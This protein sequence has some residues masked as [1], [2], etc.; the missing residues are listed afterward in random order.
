[1]IDMSQQFI[2]QATE[3]SD[4]ALEHGMEAASADERTAPTEL[5]AQLDQLRTSYWRK[6]IK[7]QGRIRQLETIVAEQEKVL[8]AVYGSRSWRI[9]SPLRETLFWLSV[10]KTRAR[11]LIRALGPNGSVERA[12]IRRRLQRGAR[13]P[14]WAEPRGDSYRQWFDQ[15]QALSDEDVSLIRAHLARGKFPHV[16]V[17]WQLDAASVDEVAD[18]VRTLQQQ[19]HPGWTANLFVPEEVTRSDAISRL[20]KTE[21]RIRC[22]ASGTNPDC[23]EQGPL[24]LIDR[25]G[26]LAPHA[27][28]LLLERMQRE[29]DIAVVLCDEDEVSSDGEHRNPRFVGKYSAELPT[30]GSVALLPTGVSLPGFEVPFDLRGIVQRV[31]SVRDSTAAHVP[32]VAF[33][34]H[35]SPPLVGTEDDRLLDGAA[36]D[37]PFITIVIPT[38]DRYELM[39]PCISS[40]LG[41]TDYPRSR[42][43]IV[44]VD[45][46]SVE[47]A[48]LVYLEKL[49]AAGEIRVLRD[50][51]KF[52]Y[53]RLNNLAV[54]RTE[55]ELLAFV[56][57]DIVVLDPLWLRRLSY[58]ATKPTVGAVGAKLL[59][60]DMTVQHGGVVVGIQGVAGHSHV[61]LQSTEPGYL[62][63]SNS[64]QAISAVT[65]ACLMMRRE[66]FARVGG[67][68][69]DL[70][71]AFNDT[72]LCVDAMA[73]G[74]RNVYIGHPL[75]IHFESK[76]RGHDDT[77]AKKALFRKEA[78]Y[79][80]SR[81]PSVFRSD[82]YYSDNLSF[83]T[84]FKLAE[85]PRT[86][87]PWH[88]DRQG[89]KLRVLI[90]SV[91]H[92]IGHGVPVV[93]DIHARHLASE[94]HEIYVG[95]PKGKNDF[96]YDG[97]RRVYLDTPQEAAI[98]A[99]TQ[100]IDC[101]IMHTP[102][103][104]STMRW[105]GP[106]VKTMVY[107]HGE[108][109]PELF[110]DAAARN[111]IQME[112][113]FCLEMADALYANSVATRDE[114]GHD[115]MGVIPLGNTHL[116]QWSD[117]MK[118]RRAS[119]RARLGW[120]DDVVAVLNVCRFH[121]AERYYKGIDE[122]CSVK[123]ALD[124]ARR[125]DQ[126]KKFVF[127][128]V[129]KGE[130]MDVEEMESRGLY[131]FAN[132]TDEQMLDMYCCA[133]V[134]AN[135]SRWEGY[136][137]GIGQ[138]LAMGLEVV[139]SDIPVHRSFPIFTSSDVDECAEE[140]QRLGTS[141][142]NVRKARAT[143]W[144]PSL[145]QLSNALNELCVP[146]SS[147]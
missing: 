12:A 31:L 105:L 40:I 74:M 99:F 18:V 140:I 112:K 7:L 60:P 123:E 115:T 114:S 51:R 95:G 133:D 122:F 50:P 137:L 11:R 47:E 106:G 124:A 92:Q 41:L 66:L 110:P 38:R 126:S 142:V 135:F 139:A 113:D 108:P 43:E 44:V 90:L 15:Y 16:H 130:R 36:D 93:L 19:L 63:L 116:S 56:N 69:E 138:A 86:F 125:G 71:V 54:A 127:V 64:T 141:T 145:Q 22:W 35:Q 30:T 147:T 76:S 42:Y 24:I 53:A 6:E 58:Q 32:F 91:T 102:P 5:T 144:E 29:P 97:C 9:T 129:G 33:H 118:A 62:G 80:R 57:N 94:G 65:G 1:M 79:V 78:R 132:V 77:P 100:G 120:G 3:R 101:A 111:A 83:E 107:D 134:Y 136:N 70:A 46:G 104:F 10:Q 128:L 8:A 17:L 4:S 82:A 68:N 13:P 84:P 87:K 61:N 103:F 49:A 67:F 27:L 34:A 143:P 72:L 20:A 121:A 81:Y 14:Q 45:N 96:P 25:P 52:N 75:L 48:L 131:V 37:L 21:P 119:A 85:P 39:E 89:E 23:P 88:R 109:P 146:A 26:R 55:G 2:S 59:Y 117:S 28:Y 73:A 98:F